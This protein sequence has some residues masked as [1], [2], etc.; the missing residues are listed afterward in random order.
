MSLSKPLTVTQK[1]PVSCRLIA[2]KSTEPPPTGQGRS[3]R[4]VADKA[5]MSFAINLQGA[6]KNVLLQIQIE[7]R[8]RGIVLIFYTRRHKP[9]TVIRCSAARSLP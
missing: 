7:V 3:S 6:P 1:F 2:T 5:G 9:A 8:R 4:A